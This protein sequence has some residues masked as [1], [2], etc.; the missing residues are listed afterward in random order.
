MTLFT[1]LAK[2]K[3]VF[4]KQ[5]QCHLSHKK[6]AQQDRMSHTSLHF[7]AL[8]CQISKTFWVFKEKI[9]MH[10]SMTVNS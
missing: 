1:V 9:E 4:W 8:A 3:K 5:L 2:V 6:C 10:L 7:Q